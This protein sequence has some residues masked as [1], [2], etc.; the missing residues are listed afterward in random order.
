MVLVDL[1]HI[2]LIGLSNKV[3]ESARRQLKLKGKAT[4]TD[5]HAT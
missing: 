2:L 3:L 1:G 5:D 4:K